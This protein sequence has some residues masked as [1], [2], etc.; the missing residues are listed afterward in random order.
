MRSRFSIRC[1]NWVEFMPR[2]DDGCDA[3]SGSLAESRL[4]ALK[5]RAT[6]Q[7]PLIR[8][9]VAFLGNPRSA[10]TAALARSFSDR[11]LGDFF[12]GRRMPYLPIT[13]DGC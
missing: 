8:T 10:F 7:T 12:A 11:G 5:D 6:D 2:L 4:A 13:P 9:A 1:R 3:L